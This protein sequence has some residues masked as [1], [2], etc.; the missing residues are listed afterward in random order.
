M[1][2]K[3]KK[4]IALSLSIILILVAFSLAFVTAATFTVP[5]GNTQQVQVNLTEGD[6]VSGT[7][8]VS[9]GSGND[10]D[11]KAIDPNGNTLKQQDRTT[12][13]SFSF[14]AATSG[15]YILSFDNSFSILTSKSVSLSYSIKS[16]TPTPSPSPSPT[17]A[18]F[19]GG[20]SATDNTILI[21]GIIA[22]IVIILVIAIF[23][24]RKKS[25]NIQRPLPPPP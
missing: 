15:T 9:G 24:S 4:S 25:N 2:T 8:S 14:T 23:V 11:F 3:M 16:P 7:I 20:G 22:I 6:S 18:P 17:A 12:S 1:V 13:S 5:A 21:G 19:L 10:I